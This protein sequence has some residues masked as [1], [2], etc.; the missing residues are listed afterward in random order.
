M[1]R[2]VIYQKETGQL[3][4][5]C[6]AMWPQT[7]NTYHAWLCKD[8]HSPSPHGSPSQRLACHR[9]IMWRT[10]LMNTHCSWT[11]LH[12]EWNSKAFEIKKGTRHRAHVVTSNHTYIAKC[13]IVAKPSLSCSIHSSSNCYVKSHTYQHMVKFI[14]RSKCGICVLRKQEGDAGCSCREYQAWKEGRHDV[15]HICRACYDQFSLPLKT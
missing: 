14:S 11:L 5:S 3:L 15:E 6:Y 2:C 1:P 4:T 8:N 10:T 13:L 12:V 7:H 9:W